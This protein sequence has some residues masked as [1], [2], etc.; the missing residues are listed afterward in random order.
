MQLLFDVE[1]D[2]N[3]LEDIAALHPE[4]VEPMVI[5]LLRVLTDGE[6][7]NDVETV[8]FDPEALEALGYLD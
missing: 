4:I 3:E 5:E 8:D 7:P 1:K 6:N 2:P